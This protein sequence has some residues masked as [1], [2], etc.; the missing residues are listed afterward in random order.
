MQMNATHFE[1][2]YMMSVFYQLHFLVRIIEYPVSQ[3][4]LLTTHGKSYLV[5]HFQSGFDELNQEVAHHSA[6]CFDNIRQAIMCGVDT[7]LEGKT[8]TPGWGPNMNVP[9]AMRC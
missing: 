2:L 7:S 8:D 4:T 3:T 6:H 5:Q 1:P 9:T